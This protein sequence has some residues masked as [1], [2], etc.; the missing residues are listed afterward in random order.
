MA[1]CMPL[2]CS[3][4][5]RRL[6]GFL[7]A[8]ASIARGTLALGSIALG[9][10]GLAAPDNP[11]RGGIFPVTNFVAYTS[12]FGLRD[13]AFGGPTEPHYGLDIAAPLGSPVLS[14]WSG[15]VSQ[16]ISDGA[17]GNGLVIRSGDYDHIYCH[18]EGSTTASTYR[19]GGLILATGQAVRAGQP[20]A[21]VGVSG[22]TTGPHLHWGLRYRGQW[23]D[24]A[25]VLRAMAESRVQPSPRRSRAP[26][27]AVLR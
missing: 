22:R 24:P 18:L 6:A 2:A 23:L 12:H 3:E 10:V 15:R 20:I 11:W 16:V 5:Q 9:P 26:N 7:P 1:P 17:C 14:W 8:L 19:T 13:G 27:V 4:A 21:R 25:R